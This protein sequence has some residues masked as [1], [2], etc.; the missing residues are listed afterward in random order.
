M[1]STLASSLAVAAPARAPAAARR[2]ASCRRIAAP[3]PRRARGGVVM[4]SEATD[5]ATSY[6][7]GTIDLELSTE[8]GLCRSTQLAM[9]L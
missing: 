3:T 9:G 6:E 1:S 5:A 2:A 4:K 7:N 8:V